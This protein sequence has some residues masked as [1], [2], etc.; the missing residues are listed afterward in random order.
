MKKLFTLFL[1]ISFNA[2]SQE[3]VHKTY[4]YLI[5][6][7]G[8]VGRIESVPEE[9]KISFSIDNGG[10]RTYQKEKVLLAFNDF[11]R[12]LVISSLPDAPDAAKIIID[13]FYNER[14]ALPPYDIIFKAVPFEI[15][16]C[17][18][19]YIRDAVNYATLDGKS[20]GSINK[21][22][23]LAIVNRD[24]SHE[25]VKDVSEVAPILATNIDGFRS[26]IDNR[27]ASPPP[28]GPKTLDRKTVTDNKPV[29]TP[30]VIV[31]API[32]NSKTTADKKPKLTTEEK[33]FY[34]KQSIDNIVEFKDFLNVIGDK[35]KSDIE[36]REAV[37]SAIALFSQGATIEVTSKNRP[38]SR[39]LSV[40]EYLKR[41]GNLS[42]TSIDIEYANL[43]FVSELSQANDG[44]YYGLVRGEQS[45]VG[46]GKDGKPLYSDV[47]PKNYKVK[48]QS[49]SITNSGESKA[50]WKVLLG[51][52]SVSE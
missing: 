6:N 33:D 19:N 21:D 35:K 45:F 15:I 48:L 12:Y 9:G 7:N 43:K 3:A 23:V 14:S 40:E 5:N 37:K 16:P 51:D 31:P 50:G 38:G 4:L 13:K 2:V 18:I 42:Y 47:V 11:G 52:V 22:N 25:I 49:E 27:K 34:S 36:K 32:N 30:P 46:Y 1:I 17:K 26:T 29:P 41:L 24:G 39:K 20:T 28:S 8:F 44:N 10:T